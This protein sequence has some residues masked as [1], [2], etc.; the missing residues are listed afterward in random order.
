[1]VYLLINTLFDWFNE[2]S[3]DIMHGNAEY[4]HSSLLFSRLWDYIF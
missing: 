3:S 1:M 2:Y 4:W